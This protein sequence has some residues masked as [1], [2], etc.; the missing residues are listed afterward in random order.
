MT[1]TIRQFRRPGTRGFTLVE[2]LITILI[3]SLT[4]VGFMWLQRSTWKISRGANRMLLSGQMIQSALESTR[5]AIALNPA[6]FATGLAADSDYAAVNGI[7]IHRHLDA[8]GDATT[9]PMANADVRRVRF[10]AK[11]M[12]WKQDSL[13]VIT[14]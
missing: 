1:K 8:A 10:T 3:I 11:W 6:T 2:I 9:M 14:Y 13:V 5:N 12:G 7:T 4:S